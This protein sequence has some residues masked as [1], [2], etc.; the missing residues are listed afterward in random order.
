MT[1]VVEL[2]FNLGLCAVCNK[3]PATQFC[4]YI[5][6]Y[7]NNLIFVRDFKTFSKVNRRGEQY[8][9]CD[10]PMCKDCGFEISKDHDLCP[11]HYSLHLQREL[12]NPFH[13]KRRT[14]AKGYLAGLEIQATFK[15]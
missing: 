2:N 12:P 7:T 14:Q 11:H 1:E 9:T 13:Q 4:D 6:E 15:R 8:E 10:L 3:N 5:T